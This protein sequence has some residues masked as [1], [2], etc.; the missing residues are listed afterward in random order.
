MRSINWNQTSSFRL[1][2]SLSVCLRTRPVLG[3]HADTWLQS[4]VGRRA[5]VVYQTRSWSSF[6][7]RLQSFITNSTRLVNMPYLCITAIPALRGV[8]TTRIYLGKT[9]SRLGFCRGTLCKRGICYDSVSECLRVC[10]SPTSWSSIKTA[11]NHQANNV[12][13]YRTQVSD[14]KGLAEIPMRSPQLGR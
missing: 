12:A 13:Q 7:A 9:R 6:E 1:S 11:K 2:V 14:A 10:L 8:I 3:I 5:V 4:P